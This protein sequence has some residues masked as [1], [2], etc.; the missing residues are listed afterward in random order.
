M[1]RPPRRQPEQA[2][3]R[4]EVL[5]CTIHFYICANPPPYNIVNAADRSEVMNAIGTVAGGSDAPP[6]RILV[7]DDDTELRRML[8]NYLE[9][10]NLRVLSAGGRAEM[11]RQFAAREPNLVLLDLK[12]D[13]EDGLDLLRE[14]RSSSDVPVIIMTGHRRDEIDRVVGLELG[15]DDYV[16]K[17]FG[18]RE[19]LARVRAVLRR[20]DA[21]ARSSPERETASGGFQFEHWHLDLRT[22]RLLKPDG[23][24]VPLTKGEYA[25]LVAFV[26]A[27]GRPLT[28]GILAAGDPRA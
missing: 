3:I 1:R 8:V 24:H 18:L 21:G 2:P 7:V 17:P 16:T 6:A 25:L 10:Q 27:P 23:V 20:Q 11:T 22:R 5:H 15:A 26:S 14:I 9:Q 28:T 12:L 13:K 4:Q 19:L